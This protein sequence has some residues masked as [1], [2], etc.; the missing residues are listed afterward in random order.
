MLLAY[1]SDGAGVRAALRSIGILKKAGIEARVIDLRP[2]KDPDEFENV[3]SKPE[4]QAEIKEI[5][6]LL[7]KDPNRML[8]IFY[9]GSGYPYWMVPPQ[10]GIPLRP[11][12]EV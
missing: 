2:S 7:D 9:D 5:T 10:P 3:Y 12:E 8:C 1:D 6:A 11:K 4:Y